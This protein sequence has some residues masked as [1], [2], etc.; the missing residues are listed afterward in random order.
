MHDTLLR[1]SPSS[2]AFFQRFYEAVDGNINV[3]KF[4][5]PQVKK[6]IWWDET[7]YWVIREGF[8]V[9]YSGLYNAQC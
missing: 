9:D 6:D 4:F 3:G 5:I 2:I 7:V 1:D 8:W